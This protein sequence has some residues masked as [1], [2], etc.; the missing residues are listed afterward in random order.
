MCALFPEK[1]E[2]L[3]SNIAGNQRIKDTIFD[4]SELRVASDHISEK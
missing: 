4:Q 3:M 2:F 1:G